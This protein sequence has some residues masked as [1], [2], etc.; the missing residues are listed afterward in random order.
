MSAA[1]HRQGAC[2]PAP[3]DAFAHAPTAVQSDR[4]MRDNRG[5]FK[6]VGSHE[7]R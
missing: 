2:A 5:C 4:R 6:R 7:T 3:G 1:L